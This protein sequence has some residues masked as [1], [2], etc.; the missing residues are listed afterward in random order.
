M[1][2]MKKFLAT[3]VLMAGMTAAMDAQTVIRNEVMAQD[4]LLYY[5]NRQ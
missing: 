3:A 4:G 1:T 2:D 5:K